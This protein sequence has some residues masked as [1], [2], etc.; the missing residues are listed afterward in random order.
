D[1][2]VGVVAKSWFGGMRESV[3]IFV[4]AHDS[5]D[6][7]ATGFGIFGGEAGEEAGDFEKHFCAVKDEE[8][9]VGGGLPVLPDV[10][11][12][13]DVDVAL[14]VAVVGNPA[15]GCGIEMDGLGF[16]AAIAAALPRE[17]GTAV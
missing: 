7:E 6:V 3:V 2:G 1:V 9:A 14:A 10:V 15:S 8:L 11:G 17:H 4:G 5:G 12:D 13:G 16:L